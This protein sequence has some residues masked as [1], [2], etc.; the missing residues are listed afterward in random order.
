MEL[1]TDVAF[2]HTGPLPYI[3]MVYRYVH[4]ISKSDYFVCPF[5]RL[6]ARTKSATTGQ[7][8]MKPNIGVFLQ[9]LSRKFKFH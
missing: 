3:F 9:N 2:S 1:T 8:F 7:I 5:V 6:L 4:K